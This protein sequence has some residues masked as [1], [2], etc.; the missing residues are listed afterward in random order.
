MRIEI[1]PKIAFSEKKWDKLSD[2][3]KETIQK[4]VKMTAQIERSLAPVKEQEA[5][6]FLQS[7]GM[8]IHTIDTETFRLESIDLQNRLAEECNGMTI[9]NAIR[10]YENQ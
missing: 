7:K 9:L 3:Q 4:A 2:S 5:I 1:A 8:Q 10:N 6:D